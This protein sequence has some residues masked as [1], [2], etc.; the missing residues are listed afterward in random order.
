MRRIGLAVALALS[1][2]LA[3]FAAETRQAEK[4]YQVGMLWLGRER[5]VPPLLGVLGPLGVFGQSLADSGYVEGKNVT[6]LHRWSQ[7]AA[8]FRDH[9]DELIRL[10]VDVLV[11]NDPEAI[12][13]AIYSTTTIPVVILTVEDPIESFPIASLSRPGGNVTGL[14]NRATELNSKL[15]ELLKECVPRSSTIAVLGQ[16]RWPGQWRKEMEDAAR[17]LGVRLQFFGLTNPEKEVEAAFETITKA[18][19]EGLV[20]LP[21]RFF[22]MNLVR[23]ARL[24]LL[25]RL[26]AIYWRADFPAAGGLMSYSP[27]D[28]YLWRRASALVARI[29]SGARPADLPVEQVDRFRLVINLNTAKA[30]RLTI[31]QTLLAR[32]DAGV[33]EKPRASGYAAITDTRKVPLVSAT[34]QQEYQRFLN[35]GLPKAFAISPDGKFWAW[36]AGTFMLPSTD[37]SAPESYDAMTAALT[38]CR[39]RSQQ[40][41]S[42]YAVDEDVVWSPNNQ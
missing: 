42:L 5:P 29:L 10:K 15:L 37:L 39:Q 25:H 40:T 13:A 12:R 14:T 36:N 2:F 19:A 6:F 41:C 28:T 18:R 7:D 32:A 16:G 9:A 22:T 34:G 1:L 24:A 35:A 26:P 27:D 3:P 4:V 11:A 8:G 30:L 33:P 23:I 17:S 21:S 38:R 31:P 20:L